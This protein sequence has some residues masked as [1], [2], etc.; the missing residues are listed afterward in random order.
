MGIPAFLS[1]LGAEVFTRP[2]PTPDTD[3]PRLDRA[4]LEKGFA[5]GFRGEVWWPGQGIEPLSYSSGCTTAQAER[6]HPDAE[7][8][9]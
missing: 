5:D 7:L 9:P 8:R 4:S 3:L 1:A 6:D 2:R